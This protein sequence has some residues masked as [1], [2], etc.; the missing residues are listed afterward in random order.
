MAAT[1]DS[2][3]AFFDSTTW[4]VARN[5]AVFF[6][7]FFWLAVAWWAVR[8][9][10]R[11]V[12]DP[13]LVAVA[14]VVVVGLPYL[15]ALVYLLLRPAELIAD[16]RERELEIRAMEERLGR[17]IL[18]C[19]KCRAEV[20]PSFRVC[21][22]CT[23]RLK[24]G[25]SGCGAPLEPL[26]QVCPHCETPAGA[27]PPSAASAAP[28]APAQ[29]AAAPPSPPAPAPAVEPPPRRRSLADLGRRSAANE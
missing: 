27:A 3:D 2:I 17:R 8:D 1:F 16:V 10:R 28:V 6:V 11:R 26:W 5:L 21:P 14:G 19:P 23:T 13:W 22:V 29:A 24:R 15:G 12:E 9:A 18:H 20:E 25:C 7:V 4:L